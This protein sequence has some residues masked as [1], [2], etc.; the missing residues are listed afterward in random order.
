MEGI[1]ES[2]SKKDKKRTKIID[3]KKIDQYQYLNDQ[4]LEKLK[5][6]KSDRELEAAKQAHD[7]FIRKYEEFKSMMEME[8][9]DWRRLHDAQWSLPLNGV[10]RK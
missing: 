8:V 10:A 7:E 3:Q 5:R 4:K 2:S 9:Q 1:G 6:E